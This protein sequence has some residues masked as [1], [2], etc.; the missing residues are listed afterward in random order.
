MIITLFKIEITDYFSLRCLHQK[1]RIM[2]LNVLKP[3]HLFH[4]FNMMLLVSDIFI[5]RLGLNN[6]E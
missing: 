1:K 4:H 2:D 5:V 3:M 6:F